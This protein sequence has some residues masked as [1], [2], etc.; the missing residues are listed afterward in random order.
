VRASRALLLT[1]AAAFASPAVAQTTAVEFRG[2]GPVELD[3][4]ID[5]LLESGAFTLIDRDTLLARDDTLHGPVLVAGAS[6]RVEGVIAGDVMIIDANVFVRPPGRVLG[7]V[8]NLGGGFYPSEQARIEGEVLY[9]PTAPYLVERRDGVLRIVGQLSA[10]TLDLDGFRGVR[11]PSYDRV[12]GLTLSVG[13][14]LLP[15]RIGHTEPL[16]RAWGGWAFEAGE[17]RGGL[18]VGLGRGV[19][20]VVIG[21][22]RSTLHNDAWI[23]S[24]IINSV[25]MLFQGKDYHN[26]YRADRLYG[27]LRTEWVG[28]RRTV[29]AELLGGIENAISLSV[30]DPWTVFGTDSLRLNPPIDE[31]RISSARLALGAE[32]ELD[33]VIGGLGGEI[34]AAGEVAGGDFEFLRY[35]LWGDWAVHGLSNHTLGVEWNVRGP[36]PGTDSLPR[37]RWTYVGGSGTLYTYEI[38]QFPGDRLVFV[39]TSYG[40]PGSP[41]LRIPLLGV[42]RLEILHHAG[43][44]WTHEQSRD[45]EQNIGLRIRF[46]FAYARVVT[47]PRNFTDDVEFSVGLSLPERSRP[48]ER[49]RR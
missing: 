2:R 22:E 34:E 42:P 18:E 11:A 17:A 12:E 3:E 32:W 37:Q 5:A 30:S 23:R 20:E 16:L 43:M 8:A 38:G 29:H 31:G 15:P 47:N 10:S 40:I 1:A 36:L 45:F 21:G 14:T 28:E 44:A 48:W 41:R 25:S 35:S 9:E 46:P 27:V 19:A 26:Y 13:G 39:E 4:R 49:P 33:E 7:D 24:D 6:L